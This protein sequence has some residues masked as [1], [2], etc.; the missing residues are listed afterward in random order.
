MA[1]LRT[2]RRAWVAAGLRALARGGPDAVRV[3]ALAATLGVSKGGFYGQFSDRGELLTE[4]LDVWAATVVDEV[5]AEVEAGGGDSRSKLKHL[6]A[7]AKAEADELLMVELAIRDWARRDPMAA[8]RV[9]RVDD[10]RMQYM[11]SLFSDLCA[12]DGVVEARC[13]LAFSLFIGSNFLAVDHDGRG[14]D[15]VLELALLELLR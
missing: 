6:F 4:M 9:R 12:D 5:I 14:R 15:E 1:L 2:P 13:L 8:E 10:R 7:I 11:R 3:E